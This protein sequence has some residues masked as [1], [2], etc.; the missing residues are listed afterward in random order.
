M[1]A[2]QSAGL[3]GFPSCVCRFLI[4]H[5]THPRRLLSVKQELPAEKSISQSGVPSVSRQAPTRS[6]LRHRC[7]KGEARPPLVR[8]PPTSPSS[9]AER[10]LCGKHI[11]RDYI[12]RARVYLLPFG[13]VFNL[14]VALTTTPV[15]QR[16]E[17]AGLAVIIEEGPLDQRL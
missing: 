9:S 15:T 6:T 10:A 2:Q 12:F 5:G 16:R 17:A 3:S 14:V 13:D 11:K 1:A 4:Q 8:S 7:Q